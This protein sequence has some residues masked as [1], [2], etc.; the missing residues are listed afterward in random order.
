MELL[1]EQECPQCG[2][3]VELIETAHVLFCGSCGTRNMVQSNSPPRYV[4]PMAGGASSAGLLLAPYLRFK[5]TIYLVSDDG[6][7]HRV[8]DTTQTANP[9]QGLPPSLGVRPQAMRLNRINPAAG[10]LF[11]P[12]TLKA[13]AIL[14]KAATVGSLVPQAGE[15]LYHRAYIG[16]HLSYIYLPLLVKEH[17]LHDGVTGARLIDLEDI[18]G[19]DMRGKRF[20]EAWKI[21]FLATLCPQCGAGLD[22]SGDCQVMTC[23]NCDTAW[24]LT[25][26]RLL[27][28]DWQ[29]QPGD[30]STRLFLPF[31]KVAT[32][33]PALDIY[34]FADFVERSNQPFLPRPQWRERVMS[35][36]VPAVRLRPKSFLQAGRQ[37]TLGQ[38]RLAP[39]EGKV[40]PNLFPATLPFSEA[41]QAVKLMLAAATASPKRIF[42]A[43]PHVRLTET[44]MQLVYLPFSDQGHDWVQP[45]TGIA[46][47]KNILRFGRSL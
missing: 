24:A 35:V 10:N 32:H 9:A 21:N 22:G 8:I 26:E 43:L 12:Q 13:S 41:R 23:A 7:E 47:G 15:Q 25:P 3:P 34:S 30:S 44:T 14:E 20:D 29:I 28:V 37:A 33:I 1:V 18:D 39:T 5:G 45:H 6:I 17:G 19:S 40:Q 38:W 16:E 31:W 4:L 42:P 11:L 36:W 27:G 46:I 2:A